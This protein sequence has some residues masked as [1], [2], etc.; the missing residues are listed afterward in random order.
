VMLLMLSLFDPVLLTIGPWWLLS[1]PNCQWRRHLHHHQ[2]Q[3]QQ[4]RLWQRC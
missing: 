1:A 2:D 4:R 3:Q